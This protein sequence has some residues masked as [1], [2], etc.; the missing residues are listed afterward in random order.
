MYQ[1]RG[2]IDRS[3]SAYNQQPGRPIKLGRPTTLDP[4]EHVVLVQRANGDREEDKFLLVDGERSRILTVHFARQASSG[5]ASAQSPR[6]DARESGEIPLGAWVLG[7]VG[8]LGHAGFV[9]FFGVA[10]SDFN[11]LKTTCSP[12]T[13]CSR[14][15]RAPATTAIGFTT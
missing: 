10:V 11:T 14:C 15:C 7:A 9:Y 4:G 2:G 8:V 12:T 5:T 13:S 3:G 1:S 6:P